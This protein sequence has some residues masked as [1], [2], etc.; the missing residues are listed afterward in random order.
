MSAYGYVD[1]QDL[2]LRSPEGGQSR[3]GLNTGHIEKMAYNANAGKGGAPMEALEIH[4]NVDG[5]THKRYLFPVTRAFDA[6]G[7]AITD[8]RDPVFQ[9]KVLDGTKQNSALAHHVAKAVGTT[10]AQIRKALATP[11]L[12]FRDWAERIVALLPEDYPLRPVDIFLEYQWAPQEGQDRTW[13]EFPRNL[14]GGNVCVPA[15]PP[16]GSW[17]E[18]RTWTETVGGRSV[19]MHGLR[20]VDRA[21]NIHPFVRTKSFMESNKGK[22]QGGSAP[23]PEEAKGAGW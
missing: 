13:P 1:D 2:S 4:A 18:Q 9:K 10:D 23:R 6:R 7:N 21:G 16:T 3:F 8:E 19:E 5:R 15:V 12:S 17:E 14:K 22:M 11:P 20:Y